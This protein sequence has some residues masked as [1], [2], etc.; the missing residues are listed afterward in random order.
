MGDSKSLSIQIMKK[1][2][3]LAL[4]LSTTIFFSYSQQQI[5]NSNFEQW[6]N[7][8]SN[9]EE[10]NEWNGIKT[11]EGSLVGFAPKTVQ[12]ST[13][14]RPGATGQ[15]CARLYT[16][17]ALG[18]NIQGLLTTGR[19][20][21]V[22]TSDAYIYSNTGNAAFNATMTSWPDSLVFWS[23]YVSGTGTDKALMRAVIHDAYNYQDPPDAASSSH[24][25]AELI[26]EIP[27]SGAGWVRYAIP[28][29][30]TGPATSPAFILLSSASNT[31]TANTNDQLFLDDLQLIYNPVTTTA[32][33]VN[34]LFYNVSVSQGANISIPF[35]KTGIFHFGN[36]FTAQLS[37]ANGSFANPIIL[38]TLNSTN[39][40]TING[41]IPA[42]TPPGTGYRVR[43][44]AT[45]PYQTA[46]DNGANI[47][48]A[49]ASNSIAP[50]ATQI[51]AANTNGTALA[52]TEGTPATS[53]VW[54]FATV[55]GGPYNAF[56]PNESGLTY[57]P[58]FA[59][60]GSYFIVC[61]SSFGSIAITSNEVQVD[62][63]Q[64]QVTPAGTQ[65]ILTGIVGTTLTVTETPI[66]ISREWK[67]ATSAGGPYQSFASPE[68]GNNYS[69][70]FANQGLYYVVCESQISGLPVISNEVIF[71]VG[72]L[73][74]NTGTIAGSPFLFS[75]SAPAAN[76]EVPFTVN[77]AFN[78]GNIFTAELSDANGSFATPTV[79]GSLTGENS[80]TISA[81]IPSNTPAG[82]GYLIRVTGSNLIVQGTDNGTALT[83]DQ[84]H[85]SI[86]PNT[87]QTTPFGVA[88]NPLTVAESQ[89]AVSREWR[90]S[91]VSGGLY[92]AVTPSQNG[93]SYAP[94][95]ATPGTYYVVCA[96]SNAYGDEVISN[97]VAITVSNGTELHTGTIVGSP[98]YVS[99]SSQVIVDVPV[100]T[101]VQFDPNNVFTVELSSVIG[102]FNPVTVIGTLAGSSP[103]GLTATIPGNTPSGSLYRMRV[104]SSSPAINGTD[105][106]TDLTVIGYEAHA[107]PVDTQYVSVLAPVSPISFTCTHPF[108][109]VEWVEQDV[110][111][112]LIPFVP[113]QTGQVFG[114][115]N[116]PSTGI[117]TVLGVGTN[118]WGDIIHTE[119]VVF[120][121]SESPAGI[122]ENNNGVKAYL[123]GEQFIVDLSASSFVS[124]DVQIINMAGQIV[125]SNK[126]QGQTIHTL[127]VSLAA[128]VYTFKISENGNIITGKILAN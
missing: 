54:K 60:A 101:N 81:I 73:Q 110:L 121:V 18:N 106:G 41:N 3:L 87:P 37:D 120:I 102:V 36:T 13:A 104:V 126:I 93:T 61:E 105:N 38:G 117:Y 112:A 7:V 80:D 113:A 69:P 9:T 31:A 14:I 103:V 68:T 99:P 35:T 62:V 90:A 58:N 21:I 50:T 77:Q 25:V 123:N 82:T 55:S 125:Y 49:D 94:Q 6:E 2:L 86:S 116:F 46:N 45:T 119:S 52:V 65:S 67:Y 32:I 78:P 24:V 17:S 63:V 127:P 75:P 19:V 84:F 33:N 23:R 47:T 27:H 115:Y 15:Y 95:F 16:G 42:G 28:F 51:I 122:Q 11:G 88:G 12:R 85:N 22:S 111:G 96:S 57:T 53:R 64:N 1:H 29:D 100:T 76:V 34:P 5:P 89:N 48:I 79:I 118:Q 72:S 30:Y 26:M 92:S 66:G 44:V 8:G 43:V 70:V 107:T 114:P 40:G 97:E 10:P 83:V 39:A 109:S 20:N 71:S 91:A 128:G 98:F 74:I 59:S 4:S 124:P 56:S 108:M